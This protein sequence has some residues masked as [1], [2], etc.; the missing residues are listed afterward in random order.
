MTVNMILAGVGGQGILSIATVLGRAALAL[1]LN[2]K[3]AEVHGMSQRGGD[4]MSCLR[5]SDA[6]IASDLIPAGKVDMIVAMEPMEAMRYLP[7][8]K[9]GGVVISSSE[10]VANVPGYPERA[11]LCDRLV[12]LARTHGLE[13]AVFDA[14]SLAREV[15]S[16]RSSNMVLLG[17]AAAW[18]QLPEYL[19]IAPQ[20]I[21]NAVAAVFAPKGEAVV[22][23]N[24]EAFRKGLAVGKDSL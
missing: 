12:S 20:E 13:C 5:L 2:L 7:Q 21:E 1:D 22:K 16:P 8:L 11:E 6:P 24:I 17:A 9:P 10:T 19:G 23:S 4:V 3:Q 18:L 14:E 15:A